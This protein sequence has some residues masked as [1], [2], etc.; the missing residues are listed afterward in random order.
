M[1]LRLVL[2][3]CGFTCLVSCDMRVY[4]WVGVFALCGLISLLAVGDICMGYIMGVLELSGL[5]CEVVVFILVTTL[6]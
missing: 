3:S 4:V 1:G 2:E 6:L 5:T